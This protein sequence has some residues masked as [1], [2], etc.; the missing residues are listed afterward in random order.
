MLFFRLGFDGNLLPMQTVFD[1]WRLA[2]LPFVFAPVLAWLLMKYYD[3]PL[4]RW[5]AAHLD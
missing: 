2:L 5:L 1:H 4:R 3:K